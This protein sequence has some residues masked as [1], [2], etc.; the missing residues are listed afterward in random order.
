[1][2][3]FL[4]LASSRSFSRLGMF[5]SFQKIKNPKSEYRAKRP[6]R[7]NPKKIQSDQMFT[8]QRIENFAFRKFEFVS[9]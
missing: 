7:T 3:R 4:L 2:S 6:S 9:N 8:M 5:S 1:L